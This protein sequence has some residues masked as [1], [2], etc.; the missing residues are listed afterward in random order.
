MNDR[1]FKYLWLIPAAIVWNRICSLP[2][3]PEYKFIDPFPMYTILDKDGNPE[4]ITI[5]GYLYMAGI[6][7]GWLTL[8]VREIL[9][10]D[11]YSV[12]FKGFFVIEI[13]SLLDFVIRYEQAFLD[14]G[15]YTF[16]FTD[17]K[18]AMYILGIW[19]FKKYLKWSG[20]LNT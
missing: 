5:Q 7:M 1:V 19:A 6:H 12:L 8:W 9:R 2:F 20:N 17:I 4:G 14:L 11:K 10:K 18:L 15:F 3:I 13:L 16:E